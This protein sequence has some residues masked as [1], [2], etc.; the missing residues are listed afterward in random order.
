MF[1]SCN[2][3]ENLMKKQLATILLLGLALGIAAAHAQAPAR[4]RA[5]VVSFD[6]K[7]L[8]VR[9]AAGKEIPVQVPDNVNISYP[10]RIAL[11]DI[12]EGDFIGTAAMPGPD[13]KLVAREVHLFAPAQ[14]GVGEGHTPW[15]LELGST[16]T[17]ASVAKSVKSGNGQE[18]TLQY[19]DGAKTVIVPPGI[20]I[21][22]AAPGDRSLLVPGSLVL[23]FGQ[24][25]ADGTVS[26]RNIQA[27]S[28]DG[29]RPPM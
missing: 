5:T 9:T 7:V 2:G 26:A 13:G 14:R 21:V 3:P 15:D 6:G 16:M 10:R 11:A 20:P 28:K 22:T 29:V 24:T 18:L 1:G 4:I 8:T 25:A 27:T 17:N 12:K 19:K 23:I